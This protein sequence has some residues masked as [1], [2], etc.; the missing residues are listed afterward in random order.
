MKLNGHM[1]FVNWQN[2]AYFCFVIPVP[3][4]ARDDG[5]VVDRLSDLSKFEGQSNGFS[6]CYLTGCR[7]KP[8]M[9]SKN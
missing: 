6:E 7:V 5:F 9:T 4:Q 2:S 1:A 8:G 3:D